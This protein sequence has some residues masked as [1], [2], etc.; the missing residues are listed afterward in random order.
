MRIGGAER[1]AVGPAAAAHVQEL[2]AILEIE[3]LG[4]EPGRAERARVL[5]GAEPL[6]ADPGVIDHAFIKSFVRENPLAAQSSAEMAET[7]VAE[8]AVHEV[9]RSRGNR[10]ARRRRDSAPSPAR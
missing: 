6:A 2:V 5:R 7:L 9:G 1:D 8:L 3:P 4:Q 10:R